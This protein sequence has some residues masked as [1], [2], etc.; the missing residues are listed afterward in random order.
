MCR[1]L[2]TT[3]SPCLALGM[4]DDLELTTGKL[5][6]K[7]GENILVVQ[8]WSIGRGVQVGTA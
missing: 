3:E 2:R 4:Q 7:G 5:G 8:L 1:D 6:E